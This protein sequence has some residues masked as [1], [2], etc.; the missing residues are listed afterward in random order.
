M[1]K[2]KE[3]M[4]LARFEGPHQYTRWFVVV[5]KEVFDFFLVSPLTL[6]DKRP[7][8]DESVHQVLQQQEFQF[9]Q[10]RQL[11]EKGKLRS[12]V[13]LLSKLKPEEHLNWRFLLNESAVYLPPVEATSFR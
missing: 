9:I 3:I 1:R 12:Q 2:S 10:L 7:T 5:D 4:K 6:T 8:L 13:I 11:K